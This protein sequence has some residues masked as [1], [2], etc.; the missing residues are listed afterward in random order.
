MVLCFD[1]EFVYFIVHNNS[2][3]FG[4]NLCVR[5]TYSTNK[6]AS[7]GQEGHGSVCSEQACA[8]HEERWQ[9]AGDVFE[10]RIH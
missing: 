6:K 7:P 1:N 5:C 3:Y 8:E 4:C 10:I 2:H 9:R